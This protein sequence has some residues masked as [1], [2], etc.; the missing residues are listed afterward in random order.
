MIKYYIVRDGMYYDNTVRYGTVSDKSN[1]DKYVYVQTYCVADEVHSW[2]K[3][4][5]TDIHNIQNHIDKGNLVKG[6][7]VEEQCGSYY[8][9]MPIRV[10]ANDVYYNYYDAVNAIKKNNEYIKRSNDRLSDMSEYDYSVYVTNKDLFHYHNKHLNRLVWDYIDSVEISAFEIEVTRGIVSVKDMSRIC[11]PHY[12]E[13]KTKEI[14]GI[15]DITKD[16]EWDGE[17]K[18]ISL[19]SAYKIRD[20]YDK[21]RELKNNKKNYNRRKEIT[22]EIEKMKY[23]K[24]E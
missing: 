2:T 8:S 12:N 16:G 19:E 9:E 7:L 17:Y 21:L 4:D 3:F 11:V 23:E 15:L 20:K 5:I 13:N 24:R 22:E 14:C 6:H 1:N 18:I 10:N